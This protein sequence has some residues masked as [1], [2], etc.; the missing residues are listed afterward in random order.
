MLLPQHNL[1]ERILGEV[2]TVVA[3]AEQHDEM[4]VVGLP[5]DDLLRGGFTAPSYS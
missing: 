4:M 5:I 3:R 2:E 1:R